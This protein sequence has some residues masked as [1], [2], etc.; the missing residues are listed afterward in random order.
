[1]EDLLRFR[2]Q[3][4]KEMQAVA[5]HSKTQRTFNLDPTAL[6]PIT[7]KIGQGAAPLTEEAMQT[8]RKNIS[9]VQETIRHKNRLPQD[10]YD[11][12]PTSASEIGWLSAKYTSLAKPY[13]VFTHHKSDIMEYGED[14]V[15][16]MNAGPYDKT[17]PVAR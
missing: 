3:I 11:V 2:D 8:K 15:K 14:Y 16:T 7:G 6:K 1:M 12:P 17:Q 5:K 10:K 9:L 4:K 13:Q